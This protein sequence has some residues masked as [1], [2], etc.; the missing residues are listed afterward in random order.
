[1]ENIKANIAFG[2][3]SSNNTTIIDNKILS[4]RCEG[5]YLIAGGFCYISRN[6]IQDNNEGIVS[7]TSLPEIRENIVQKNK[8]N[9]IMIMKDTQCKLVNN[10]IKENQGIGLYIRDKSHGEVKNNIVKLNLLKV[11]K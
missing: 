5:I 8:S 9:G 4:G 7:I 6:V 2:G 11:N 1:M 3:K 10:T